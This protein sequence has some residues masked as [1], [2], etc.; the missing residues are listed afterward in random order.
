MIYAYKTQDIASCKTLPYTKTARINL[1]LQING[2][3]GQGLLRLRKL[4]K[5]TVK[6]L[7][8]E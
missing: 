4:L 5:S 2:R 3:Q 7:I 8:I 1:I 6:Q